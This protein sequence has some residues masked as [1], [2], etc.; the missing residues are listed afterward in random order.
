MLPGEAECS[1]ALCRANLGDSTGTSRPPLRVPTACGVNKWCDPRPP[2][3]PPPL[4]PLATPGTIG[5]GRRDPD[6]GRPVHPPPWYHHPP[7]P[8]TAKCSHG[9]ESRATDLHHRAGFTRALEVEHG[10]RSGRRLGRCP[11]L[12][13]S[14]R[15][16]HVDPTWAGF[17]E[18][19]DHMAEA[20]EEHVEV[21][22]FLAPDRSHRR[23]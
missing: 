22:L 17:L 13:W 4:R 21:T 7:K 19:D 6:V 5:V 2:E 23:R 1:E 20:K 18:R 16:P 14:W 10:V 3:R 8:P 11:R 15:G 12:S 9:A